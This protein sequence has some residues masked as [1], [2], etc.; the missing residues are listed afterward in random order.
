[1]GG[2]ARVAVVTG[3]GAA[4]SYSVLVFT[5]WDHGLQGDR[6]TKLK[7]NNFRYRLQVCVLENKFEIKCLHKYC[8]TIQ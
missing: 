7:Q 5:G 1:M 4:G 3:G 8:L 2:T 6:V